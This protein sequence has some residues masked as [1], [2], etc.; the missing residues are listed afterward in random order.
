MLS[1]RERPIGLWP[2]TVNGVDGFAHR[3]V[4]ATRVVEAR[5]Q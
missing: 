3:S 5:L 4:R 2:H 1:K